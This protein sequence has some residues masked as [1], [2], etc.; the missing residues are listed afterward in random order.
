MNQ[1]ISPMTG[2]HSF[3]AYND[4]GQV[5]YSGNGFILNPEKYGLETVLVFEDVWESGNPTGR[6]ELRKIYQK[7]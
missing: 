1:V 7:K 5:V 2:C 3:V 4:L 6:K